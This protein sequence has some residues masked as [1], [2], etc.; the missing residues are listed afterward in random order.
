MWRAIE[1][2]GVSQPERD[3][4]AQKVEAIRGAQAAGIITGDIAAVDILAMLFALTRSWLTATEALIVQTDLPRLDPGRIEAHRT[5]L[6][7][8]VRRSFL[9]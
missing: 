3:S 5:A 6:A 8:A 4:F 2:V 9:A 1:Q 7:R